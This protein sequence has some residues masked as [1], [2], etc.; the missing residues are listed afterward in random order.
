LRASRAARSFAFG[1]SGGV[2]SFSSRSGSP[3]VIALSRSRSKFCIRALLL[4]LPILYHSRPRL[5]HLR[6]ALQIGEC[7]RIARRLRHRLGDVP[8]FGGLGGAVV[9]TL[10]ALRAR[11]RVE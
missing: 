1:L 4:L 5:G 2:N 7:R 6:A 11:R 3:L 10:R 9:Q 8:E